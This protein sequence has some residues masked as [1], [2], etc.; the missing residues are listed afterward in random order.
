VAR[1]NDFSPTTKREAFAL[2]TGR[3]P[4][5]GCGEQTAIWDE[6]AS[7]TLRLGDVAHIVAASDL[8]PRSPAQLSAEEREKFV[9][10]IGHRDGLAN[11]V[12]LCTNCHRKADRVTD[13]FTV[14]EL[15]TAQQD[16]RSRRFTNDAVLDPVRRAGFGRV[17]IDQF[18]DD[19][20]ILRALIAA[21][22]VDPG[23]DTYA[24]LYGD[25]EHL[26]AI[27]NR[28]DTDL[29]SAKWQTL[30]YLAQCAG[31][32]G[33]WRAAE[34]FWD[35]ASSRAK[36]SLE[37]ASTVATLLARTGDMAKRA[38][39]PDVAARY[40]AEAEGLAPH[41]PVVV[42]AGLDGPL[43]LTELPKLDVLKSA[44]PRWQ[45]WRFMH[46]CLALLMEHDLSAARIE[47]AALDPAHVSRAQ[48]VG[49]LLNLE[50]EAARRAAGACLPFDSRALEDSTSQARSV[51]ADLVERNRADEAVRVRLLLAE[52]LG[53][54]ERHTEAILLLKETA[55]AETD[56]WEGRAVLATAYITAGDQ[57]NAVRALAGPVS[58]P[59]APAARLLRIEARTLHVTLP[60]TEAQELMTELAD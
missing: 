55:S 43:P 41:A 57:V 10:L 2:A 49:L 11:A 50:V 18:T 4:I 39:R 47:F 19:A 22:S 45:A 26:E 54:L 3:C 15:F 37:P 9:E 14:R 13:T 38:R 12:V 33:L 6:T 28:C 23:A 7:A 1:E 53:F 42:L 8:G 59:D 29:A 24:W 31:R 46:R 34:L 44:E 25:P 51:I 48:Y 56:N 60:D 20:E 58:D 5:R 52:A 16:E 27:S 30:D 40:F 17:G 32:L 35:H 36:T 21:I